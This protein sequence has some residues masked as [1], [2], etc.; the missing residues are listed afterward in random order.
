MTAQSKNVIQFPR[1]VV[2]EQKVRHCKKMVQML[3]R[4][5]EEG[6]RN[7]NNR[8]AML[9]AAVAP[10]ML[11]MWQDD[12]KKALVEREMVTAADAIRYRGMI[13]RAQPSQNGAH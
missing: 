11:E 2:A 9:R 13:Y 10:P 8:D 7:P 12:L 4:H 1:E 6:A 3:L 5:I